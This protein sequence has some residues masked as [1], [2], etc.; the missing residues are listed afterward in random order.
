MTSDIEEIERIE[1]SRRM[2]IMSKVIVVL[3]VFGFLFFLRPDIP[4]SISGGVVSGVKNLTSTI[5]H[6]E[7]PVEKEEPVVEVKEEKPVVE[8][9]EEPKP[10]TVLRIGS[11]IQH[12][13]KDIVLTYVNPKETYC[14][15][16]VNGEGMLIT[17]GTERIV[18]GIYIK[19][20][21]PSA[22]ETCRV[23]LR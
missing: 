13:G 6:E 11:V 8:V 2:K 7:E 18:N 16:R 4:K 10:G 15:L 23:T 22:A 1:R 21:E 3:L 20:L 14:T 5:Q 19:V 17:N 9:K 12:R